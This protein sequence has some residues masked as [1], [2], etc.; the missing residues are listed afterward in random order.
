MKLSPQALPMVTV[1]A[2]RKNSTSQC[3]IV[4]LCKG[5]DEPRLIQFEAGNLCPGMPK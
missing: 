3:N 5:A 4:T 2:G 1:I